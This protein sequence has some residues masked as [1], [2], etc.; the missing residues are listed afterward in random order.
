MMWDAASQRY[1]PQEVHPDLL[2]WSIIGAIAQLN[3]EVVVVV[4]IVVNV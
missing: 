4:V 2:K 3:S 1:W